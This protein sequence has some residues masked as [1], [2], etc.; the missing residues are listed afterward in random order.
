MSGPR[1]PSAHGGPPPLRREGGPQQL[2]KV[3]TVAQPQVRILSGPN[4]KAHGKILAQLLAADALEGNTADLADAL[5]PLTE[6][7][8]SG[9]IAAVLA[10][11]KN[12]AIPTMAADLLDAESGSGEAGIEPAA[13]PDIH[14][15]IIDASLPQEPLAG[16]G[17]ETPG[18][19]VTGETRTENQ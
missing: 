13:S 1:R 11:H 12:L 19:G 7:I 17:L 2:R 18:A 8:N 6:S 4:T 10:K 3:F 15:T 16:G 9:L 5:A 14:R